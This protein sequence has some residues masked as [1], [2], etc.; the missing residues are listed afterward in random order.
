MTR[1]AST[2]LLRRLGLQRQMQLL[3]RLR[4]F[5]ERIGAISSWFLLKRTTGTRRMLVLFSD[6]LDESQQNL[7]GS[8]LLIRSSLH[9]PRED[10]PTPT[11]AVVTLRGCLP[12]RKNAS[13]RSCLRA[14]TVLSIRLSHHH[15]QQQQRQKARCEKRKEEAMFSDRESRSLQGALRHQRHRTR[16]N[17]GYMLP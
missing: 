1:S 10:T 8:P 14:A 16:T 2:D 4:G 5:E 7:K 6:T 12:T 9:C 3:Q 15:H 11:A 13:A 17:L